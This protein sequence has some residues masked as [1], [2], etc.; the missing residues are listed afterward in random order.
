M[1]L[2]KFDAVQFSFHSDSP[3]VISGCGKN[4]T[5]CILYRPNFCGEP[6]ELFVCDHACLKRIT[7][8]SCV[9]YISLIEADNLFNMVMDIHCSHFA[10]NCFAEDGYCP[11]GLKK[12]VSG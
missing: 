6:K 2:P 9:E 11:S 5:I 10:D 1:S 8:E 7:G 12:L 3:C 4:I